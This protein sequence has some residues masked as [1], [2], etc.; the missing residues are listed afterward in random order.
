MQCT[1][2]RS[3]L[4]MHL[5][6]IKRTVCKGIETEEYLIHPKC[7][8]GHSPPEHSLIPVSDVAVALL[9][10]DHKIVL[11]ETLSKLQGSPFLLT[12]DLLY[13]EPYEGIG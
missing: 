5:L 13:F 7:L 1:Q 10:R 8:D 6:S 12:E 2:L 4:I 3:E 9:Q 11:N